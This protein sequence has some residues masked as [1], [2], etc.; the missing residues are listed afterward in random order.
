MKIE[1]SQV[2]ATEILGEALKK[3][4]GDLASGKT[5]VNVEFKTYPYSHVLVTLKHVGESED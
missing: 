1:L 5:L 3:Y 2:E 4:I